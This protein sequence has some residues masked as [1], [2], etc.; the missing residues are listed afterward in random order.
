MKT[1][2]LQ[3]KY[4]LLFSFLLLLLNNGFAVHSIPKALKSGRN[5]I[6]VIKNQLSIDDL[7]KK[8]RSQIESQI[9]TKLKL[10][11]RLML[12]V[13]QRNIR[14]AIKKGHSKAETQTMLEEGKFEFN[15]I[16]FVLGF[17]LGFL[18]ILIV[19]LIIKEDKKNARTSSWIGLGVSV[20]LALLMI[21]A[22]VALFLRE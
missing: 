13:I 6:E 21:M 16:G 2:Q 11:E 5:N 18:G 7:L 22:L 10:K 4:L 12:A 19:Y 3:P 8:D 9:G 20:I 15:V 14:K 1:I 17:T